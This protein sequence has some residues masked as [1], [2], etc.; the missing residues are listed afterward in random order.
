MNKQSYYLQRITL[1]IFFGLLFVNYGLWAQEENSLDP[2]NDTDIQLPFID[3]DGDGINDLLQNG[4][5]LRFMNR[6]K[7][8]QALWD[9]LN[10]EIVGEGKDRLVDLD[11]D[12]VGDVSLRDFLRSKM[13]ELIDTDGDGEADTP[14]KEILKRRFQSFDRDGD[15]LPDEFT[16][17][18]MRERMK[19]IQ[20]WRE[21][22]HERMKNGLPPFI[23][24]NGD[25]IPDNLPEGFGF[26]GRFHGGGEGG[27]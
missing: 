10:A 1:I 9:Q 25:G 14:L 8:R 12:G 15:G 4:W 16:G 19:N 17:E 22:I 5:G 11:G 23:D 3:R 27:H 26:R 21:Q 2:Q 18:E 13:D 7:Q 24:E 6:Y 20:E